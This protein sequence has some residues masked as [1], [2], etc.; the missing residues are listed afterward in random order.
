MLKRRRFKQTIP[1]EERLLQFAQ[2]TR[3]KA[4]SL[5]PGLNAI[6]C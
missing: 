4:E 1:L 2:E 6:D 3:R 5:P